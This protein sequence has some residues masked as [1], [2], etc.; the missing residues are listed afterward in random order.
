MGKKA[1]SPT[2]YSFE[3]ARS[4]WR[5]DDPEHKGAW[6]NWGP[7]QLSFTEPH[8]PD[9]SVRNLKPLYELPA[10][11][12]GY[13]VR[14]VSAK[15]GDGW[16]IF[17][18][19]PSWALNEVDKFSNPLWD[20]RPVYAFHGVDVEENE[21]APEAVPPNLLWNDEAKRLIYLIMPNNFSHAQAIGDAY[22]WCER[23]RT[24]LR[25]IMGV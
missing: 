7:P 22:G 5:D 11:P 4:K 25:Q 8:V 18:D 20:I 1:I 9:G 3:L 17:S 14:S 21:I 6:D 2:A 10:K 19:I 23:L 12:S 13:Q 16:D 24:R 15:P